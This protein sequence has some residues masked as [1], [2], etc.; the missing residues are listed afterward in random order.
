MCY[1]FVARNMLKVKALKKRV[2]FWNFYRE[3]LVAEKEEEKR[4]EDGFGAAHRAVYLYTVRLRR[5]RPL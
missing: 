3:F 2:G 5:D 4:T 1:D